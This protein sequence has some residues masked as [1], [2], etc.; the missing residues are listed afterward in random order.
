MGK[1]WHNLATFIPIFETHQNFRN[2]N[3]RDE[4]RY[5]KEIE[6]K[7]THREKAPYN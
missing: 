5:E 6:L 7:D 4:D 2:L 1:H 3:T